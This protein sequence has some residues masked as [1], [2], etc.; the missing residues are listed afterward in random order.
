[1]L[2][3]R[4]SRPPALSLGERAGSTR[5]PG[6]GTGPPLPPASVW[7]VTEAALLVPERLLPTARLYSRSAIAELLAAM[8][9]TEAFVAELV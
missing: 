2:T 8:R 6:R 5:R 9:S 3:P 7:L 1:M 4:I